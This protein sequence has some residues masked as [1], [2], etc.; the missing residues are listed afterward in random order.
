MEADLRRRK[1]RTRWGA[2]LDDDLPEA[3]VQDVDVDPRPPEER[4][5]LSFEGSGSTPSKRKRSRWG[6]DKPDTGDEAVVGFIPFRLARGTPSS[7]G[8]PQSHLCSIFYLSKFP[9]AGNRSTCSSAPYCCHPAI[10]LA[11]S[12]YESSLSGECQ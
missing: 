7:S 1:K 5:K 12:G 4:V 8:S 3:S 11:S 6:G 2:D 9:P 10:A